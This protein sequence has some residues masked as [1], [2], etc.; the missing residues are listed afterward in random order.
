MLSP[1][2][3]PTPDH[4]S[5]EV[6]SVGPQNLIPPPAPL[7]RSS[8]SSC[9]GSSTPRQASSPRRCPPPHPAWSLTPCGGQASYPDALCSSL[10]LQHPF[11]VT[12]A[13]PLYSASRNVYFALCYLMAFGPSC[14]GRE[15][16]EAKTRNDPLKTWIIS[17][18]SK[19]FALPSPADEAS[20]SCTS[21]WTGSRPRSE[22]KPRS[23]QSYSKPCLSV[24]CYR[25]LS[26]TNSAFPLSTR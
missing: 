5:V 16:K 3:F 2:C 14:S 23:S 13:P 22:Q 6:P 12:T 18:W 7:T 20:H 4:P 24:A 8:S 11:C 21:S 1:G 9:L 26:I 15:G 25:F 10:G 17:E 19:Q